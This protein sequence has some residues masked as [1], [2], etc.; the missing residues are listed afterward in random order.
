MGQIQKLLVAQAEDTSDN[1]VCGKAMICMLL[2]VEPIF[3]EN[4][5]FCTGVINQRTDFLHTGFVQRLS[6]EGSQTTKANTH[7]KGWQ[8]R[9][10]L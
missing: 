2:A 10:K 6:P 7:G 3:T 9:S 8:H 1:F 5:A 4:N